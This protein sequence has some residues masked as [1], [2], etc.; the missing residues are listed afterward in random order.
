MAWLEN[1]IYVVFEDSNLVHVYPDKEPFDELRNDRIE[2]R[3]MQYPSDIAASGVSR[4]IFISD[5]NSRCVWRIQIP[6]KTI[7]LGLIQKNGW[8]WELSVNSSDE[9]IVL[10]LR[11]PRYYIDMHRCVDFERIKSIQVVGDVP[12][13]LHHVVQS[14]NGNFIILHGSRDIPPVY[15]ISEVSIDGTKTIRSTES[16]ELQDWWPQHLSIDEDDNIFVADQKNDVVILFNP[17][18]DEHRNLL[19]REEHRI[20]GPKTLCYVRDEHLSI[21]SLN[22]DDHHIR[23]PQRLCYVRAKQMLI[24]GHGWASPS[25][26]L[27]SLPEYHP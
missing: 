2:I 22:R 3:R 5:L 21:A 25:V 8:P 16:S 27:F 26:S 19:S 13:V 14:S 15:R 7:S 18:L 12:K 1:K 20:S 11:D 9:L 17:R 23:G 6:S 10:V 24:V 4:A